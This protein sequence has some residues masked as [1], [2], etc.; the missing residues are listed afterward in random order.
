MSAIAT[1]LAPDDVA[2]GPDGRP[3]L[4]WPTCRLGEHPVR[5]AR[6]KL[7]ELAISIPL[8][9]VLLFAFIALY[10]ILTQTRHSTHSSTCSATAAR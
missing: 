7:H 6:N 3:Q 8:G 5:W 2:P 4:P 10:Y 1:S 9:H